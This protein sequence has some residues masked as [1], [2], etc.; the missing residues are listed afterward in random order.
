[1]GT[2][3][4]YEFA[5]KPDVGVLMPTSHDCEDDKCVDRSAVSPAIVYVHMYLGLQKMEQ[6]YLRT[7]TDWNFQ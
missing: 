7:S 5:T 2:A 1:M 4:N 3:L 6:L